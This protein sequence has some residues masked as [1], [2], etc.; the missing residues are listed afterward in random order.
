MNYFVPLIFSALEL[1]SA[2]QMMIDE[3]DCVRKELNLYTI[4]K[5]AG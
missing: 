3:F 2:M 1:K 5:A 4:K